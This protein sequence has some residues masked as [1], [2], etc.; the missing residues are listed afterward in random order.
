MVNATSIAKDYIKFTYGITT[1]LTLRVNIMALKT[2]SGYF[3]RENKMSGRQGY[4]VS[5]ILTEDDP[6]PPPYP[7][8]P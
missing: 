6:H 1:Q 3:M 5:T 7:V 8:L 4:S 2:P